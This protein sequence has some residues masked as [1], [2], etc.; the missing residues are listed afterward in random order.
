MARK[1]VGRFEFGKIYDPDSERKKQLA[2]YLGEEV[3]PE[4]FRFFLMIRRR[5]LREEPD[6]KIFSNV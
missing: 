2:R 4:R 3:P 5:Y 1:G 6:R